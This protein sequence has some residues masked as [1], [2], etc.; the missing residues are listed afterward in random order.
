MNVVCQNKICVFYKDD[1]CTRQDIVLNELGVCDS[2]V[3]TLKLPEE[4]LSIGFDWSAPFPE[5]LK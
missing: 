5:E 4:E 1:G 3:T 2:Y